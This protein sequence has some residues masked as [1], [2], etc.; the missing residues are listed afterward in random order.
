MTDYL[1]DFLQILEACVRSKTGYVLIAG[2]MNAHH[3]NWGIQRNDKKGDALMD[4][5][6]VLGLVVCNKSNKPTFQTRI[7]NSIPDITIAS[8]ELVIKLSDWHVSDNISLSDHNYIMNRYNHI[9]FGNGNKQTEPERIKINLKKLEDAIKTERLNMTLESTNF[10]GMA[11]FMENTIIDNC[12][13]V[14]Q[15]PTRRKT[16]YWW[17]EEIAKL[18]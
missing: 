1:K 2:D 6:Q 4:M 18:N 13:V 8:P 14:I 16:V 15:A 7:Y 11:T 9:T 10:D 5:V 17:N 3:T 12:G